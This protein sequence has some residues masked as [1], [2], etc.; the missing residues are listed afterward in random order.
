MAS[1]SLIQPASSDAKPAEVRPAAGLEWARAE[2]YGLAAD[3]AAD[4]GQTNEAG[5]QVKR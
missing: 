5:M 3:V 2:D 4:A 1:L